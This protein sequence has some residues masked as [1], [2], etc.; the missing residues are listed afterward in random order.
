MEI[1]TLPSTDYS[2]EFKAGAIKKIKAENRR[3]DS[4]YFVEPSKI[5][6]DP[7]YNVRV[8]SES[9]AKWVRELANDMKL[10][11]FNLDKPIS[12][13]IASIG[14]ED[15]MEVR[16]GHTRLAAA[17]LAI[18]EGAPFDVIPVIIKPKSE[19]SVDQTVDLIRSNNGR[20]LTVYET[21]IV[22]KRLNNMELTEQEIS[23][24]L[25]YSQ[26]YVSGLLLLA[27][28]PHAISLLVVNEKVSAH[29]VIDM[30]RKHGNAEALK[31]L[32]LAVEDATKAG[33]AKV[34]PGQL[35]QAVRNKAIR[36]SATRLYET[37]K[38]IREDKGYQRLS[39]A[40]RQKLDELL[41]DLSE[42]NFEP[43]TV[44]PRTETNTEPVTEPV[45]EA[46]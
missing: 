22:I 5:R 39:E 36:K 37:A 17:L 6:V 18:S 2:P 9:Y 4:T 31:H 26:N 10:N 35:P 34:K 28:A 8:Q 27:A 43:Q 41:A 30:I 25:G 19:N 16:M 42:A 15:V 32:K 24:R 13:V 3:S 46:A 7:N 44:D 38:E 14:G 33:K 11:G 29:V 1:T 23:Q 40:T 20:P 45:A 12:V 21:S